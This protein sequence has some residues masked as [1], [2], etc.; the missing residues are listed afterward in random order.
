M[1][2]QANLRNP[3][4]WYGLALLMGV[5]LS[6]GVGDPFGKFQAQRFAELIPALALLAWCYRRQPPTVFTNPAIGGWYG[7]G[8]LGFALTTLA[9][10]FLG[11]IPWISI[12][13]LGLVLLQ[14]G[15]LPWIQPVWQRHGEDGIRILALLA[16]ALIGVDVGILVIAQASEISAYAWVVRIL[17]GQRPDAFPYL[18]LNTRW[19][20]QAALLLLWVFLP[21]LEQLRVGEIRRRRWF[22]WGICLAIPALAMLQFVFTAG[23]GA[24]L[25]TS[26]AVLALWLGSGRA[27]GDRRQML[28]LGVLIMLVAALVALLLNLVIDQGSLL[29]S[30]ALRNARDLSLDGGADDRRILLWG[31]FA[32]G[33]WA[34]GF[35]GQGIPAVASGAAA[36]TPHNLWLALVF[37]SGW[38][39]TGFAG[40]LATGFVPGRWRCSGCQMMALPVLISL[41]VYPLVDDLWL[42]S[43]SLAL[44]LVLLP[45]LK[46]PDSP[47]SIRSQPRWLRAFAFPLS[48]YRLLAL[49]GVLLISLALAVPGGVGFRPS[50]LVSVPGRVCLLFF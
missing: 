6:L 24:L 36:C 41:L 9:A 18:F 47:D 4:R 35:W 22:W 29:S 46:Q 7:L 26:L 17:P 14:F 16:V 2:D 50:D 1:I 20:N 31:A 34:H 30:I 49:I 13:F 12:G 43:L 25:A 15:L 21:L 5:L 23:R 44:L 3:L 37:W 39:G 40:L 33:V 8:L 45:A 28:R 32:R 19:A 48:T 27:E 42:R 11:P 10:G 38:L